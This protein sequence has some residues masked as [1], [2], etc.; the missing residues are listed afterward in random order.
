MKT[1]KNTLLSALLTALAALLILVMVTAC[2][3][4]NAGIIPAASTGISVSTANVPAAVLAT[5]AQNFPNVKGV[6]WTK[7]SPYT[8]QSTFSTAS[9]GGRTAGSS[10]KKANYTTSGQLLY[11]HGVIDPATLPAAITT[12][13]TT[14]YASYSV[15]SAASRTNQTT[16][17]ITGYMVDI[18]ANNLAY[19]LRFDAAG[20]FLSVENE[21]GSDEGVAVAL[22]SLPAPIGNYLSATYPGYVFSNARSYMLNG[23]VSGYEVAIL[24]AGVKNEIM[25]DAAG[26]FISVRTGGDGGYGDHQEGGNGYGS[27]TAITQS[28]LPAAITSYLSASY[29][30]ATFQGGYAYSQNGVLAGY[31]VT[32]LLNNVYTELLF[33]AAGTFLSVHTGNNGGEGEHNGG[34]DNHDGNHSGSGSS[35]AVIAQTALPA[36]ITTYLT[37][38]YAGYTFVS[39][40]VEQNGTVVTGYEVRFTLA[41]KNYEA[42]FNATGTLIKLH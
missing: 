18:V 26:T 30:T 21:D 24:V 42:E 28:A 39:A 12:Y 27:T 5:Q 3:Q 23:V 4:Q 1:L 41:G 19:E 8:F 10:Q 22:A 29:A 2:S 25:F 31:E 13:L 34:G 36:A 20:K 9:A 16:G 33:N 35:D 32:V 7:V 38:N 37:T 17:A 14:T 11:T 15:V 6:S 40:K